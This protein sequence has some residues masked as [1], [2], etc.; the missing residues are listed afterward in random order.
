M[1][2]VMFSVHHL[3]EAT[4]PLYFN[5]IKKRKLTWLHG[6]P[7]QLSLLAHLIKNR[8]LGDL[9]D[10]KIITVGAENMLET[11]RTIIEEV[12]R[13]PI[14]QHYGLAEG[15][16]NISEQCDGSL[17]ADQDF[18][19]VEFIPVDVNNP[20]LCRIIGTNYN[21][22]AFPLI[23]YDTGDIALIDWLRD[24]TPKII[25]IDGRQEDY[26]TLPNGVKLGRLDHI[27]KD[28]TEVQ[29]AQIFQPDIHHIV[30]RIVKGSEYDKSNQ[31]ELVMNE[32]QKRLGKE[33]KIE[34]E[35]FDRI[36]RTK[37][38]KLKFV[39]SQVK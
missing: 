34:I 1:K 33:I 37:S 18:A 31:H 9:P 2:Q 16:A 12:F 10:V 26:I 11:Q 3:N 4:V 24:G 20:S 30:L 15:V 19:F 13:A 32:T 39:I 14:K 5:L 8:E 6:Y 27:F 36:P 21:N 22:I 23:R 28:M 38:G 35:Y 25:S 29:E 17:I 7:S